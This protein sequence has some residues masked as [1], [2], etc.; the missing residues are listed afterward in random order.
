M[1]EFGGT[2]TLDFE[3]GVAKL[4]FDTLERTAK[5]NEVSLTKAR[6][7]QHT[8]FINE[9]K[10]VCEENQILHSL[11]PVYAS[12]R[13]ALI[14]NHEGS[15]E[16][17]PIEN[18]LIQRLVT[19]LDLEHPKDEGQNIAIGISYNEKG[20]SVSFGTNVHVCSNQQVFGQNVL[21]TYGRGKVSFDEMKLK[22][23]E[24]IEGFEGLRAENYER[25][26][27]MK[28][29]GLTQDQVRQII[30][31]LFYLAVSDNNGEE[32]NAPLNQLQVANL[33]RASYEPMYKPQGGNL[34]VWDVSQWGTN[35]LKPTCTDLLTLQ[36][37]NARFCDF[38]YD[39]YCL[40]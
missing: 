28:E 10:T 22:I 8:E 17:C 32:V 16:Q 30:G 14:V 20:I 13:Q 40:N 25:I 29:A 27:R 19:R 39:N 12:Q 21:Y 35:G 9:L 38:M 3:N 33:V 1:S 7:I 34:T 6:P 5:Y 31:D 4:S 26:Q 15:K 36:E 23:K 37:T 2:G 11:A 18:F 24:W